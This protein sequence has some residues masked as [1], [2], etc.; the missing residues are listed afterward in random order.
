MPQWFCGS[1]L[2]SEGVLKPDTKFKTAFAGKRLLQVPPGWSAATPRC[3]CRSWLA[4]EGVLKPDT[5]FKTAFAGKPAPTGP[6]QCQD[7]P[8]QYT[9]YV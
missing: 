3:M 6:V 1:W 5:K 9:L 2:A 8:V 7:G 4:S